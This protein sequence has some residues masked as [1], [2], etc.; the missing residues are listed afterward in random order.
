MNW[1][2]ACIYT[3]TEG[4]DIV[5]GCLIGLNITGFEIK[6]SKVFEDFLDNKIANWDYID[7]DLLGLKDCETSVTV[8]IPENEQGAELLLLIKEEL[9]EL[10]QRDNE[11]KFGRLEVSLA[12]I[13]EEDWANNWKQYFKPIEIGERLLI[14]PTW[15]KVP[16]GSTGRKILEIDPAP[17]FGTGQHNTTQLC[18]ENI[19]RY[20]KAGDRMLDLGCGSGILSA[21]GFLLGASEL[22]V[23][24]I[25]ENSVEIASENLLQNG[26]KADCF[27]AL[28]GN[29]IDDENIRGLIGG[30]YDI[31]CANI[32]SDILI[33]MSGVFSDFLKDKGILIVSGIISERRDEVIG[34]I[35]ECGFGLSDLREREGWVSAVFERNTVNIIKS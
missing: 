5:C 11:G 31:V 34:I 18:L 16:D 19:E 14:K 22:T 3:T 25:D 21:A 20:I 29:V 26:V 32:V 4:A 1:T 27:K 13:S 6:D 17:S 9:R 7:D 10:K 28:C 35:K 23:V 30:G 24:D 15:E 12:N 2:E 8:Y 33:A